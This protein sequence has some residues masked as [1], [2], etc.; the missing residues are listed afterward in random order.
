VLYHHGPL[1]GRDLAD[2]R[3][4]WARVLSF[5]PD[6]LAALY[7]LGRVAA[8]VGDRAELERLTERVLTLSP[9]GDR[10]LEARALRAFTV[11]DLAEQE[12]VT[13]ELRRCGDFTL[14]VVLRTVATYS[15]NLAGAAALARVATEDSRTDDFRALAYLQLASLELARGRRRA[16]VDALDA[17]DRL[18][19]AFAHAGALELPC[20]VFASP[21][22]LELRGLFAALPF[23]P[24]PAD[25]VR[26]VRAALEAW[27]A[28]AAPRSDSPNLFVRV[29]NGV[30][31]HLRAYLLAAL[32]L[33]LGD[34]S[35]AERQ[36]AALDALA[37]A[38]GPQLGAS[39]AAALAG[40]VRAHVAEARGD[41]SAALDALEQVRPAWSYD[42]PL[43]SP[44]FSLA[45]ARFA[46]ARLLAARG[47]A[48]EAARWFNSFAHVSVYDLVFLA[49]SHRE[50][51][52][53]YDRLGDGARAAE[54]YARFIALWEE[55]D[56]ELRP[57]V[58]EAERRLVALRGGAV[59]EAAARE[60]TTP[61]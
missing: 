39:L 52:A 41:A 54:Q 31:P 57:A 21:N 59:H 49:P 53:L 15:G 36:A 10:A 40:A 55:C 26:W 35:A 20:G 18:G 45:L 48:D 60:V 33:R 27:D 13:R 24:T 1:S 58:A 12:R 47:R 22:A 7:H 30:H 4:A 29:H 25:E 14:N 3:E 37:A 6:H 61:V 9:E 32:S 11:G 43:A 2:S 28:A 17:A 38:G 5:E 42:P 44:F 16:A 50:R 8:V 51:A 56:D 23:I 34:V 19:G 46:R